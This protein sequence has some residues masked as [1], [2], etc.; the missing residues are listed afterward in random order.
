MTYTN[1]N[2]IS[3]ILWP[4]DGAKR[5]GGI[6]M[7]EKRTEKEKK[8]QMKTKSSGLKARDFRE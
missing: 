1:P 2:P 4:V 6:E 3:S 8:C 7:V 5:G